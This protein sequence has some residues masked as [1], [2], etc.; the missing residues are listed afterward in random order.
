MDSSV[1]LLQYNELA[2]MGKDGNL[3]NLGREEVSWNFM[4]GM[5]IYDAK[6]ISFSFGMWGEIK[7]DS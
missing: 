5:H 7:R 1:K 6:R 3:S 2:G 4:Y